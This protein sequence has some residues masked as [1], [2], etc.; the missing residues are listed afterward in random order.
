[1]VEILQISPN[2]ITDSDLA[3]TKHIAAAEQIPNWHN[4]L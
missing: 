2:V 3:I 1:M 4:L